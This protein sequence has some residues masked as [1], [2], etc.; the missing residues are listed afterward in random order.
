M[1]TS[2]IQRITQEYYE[3]IYTT[4]F[5][6]LEETNKTLE[7]YNLSRVNH[8]E[9]E[10]LNTLIISKKIKTAIENLPKMKV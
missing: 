10:N 7:V 1:D 3:R 8:E 2:E 9:L 4:K 6:N 5:Y